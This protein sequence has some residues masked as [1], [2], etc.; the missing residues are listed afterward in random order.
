ME[1]KFS[2]QVKGVIQYSRE[3]A[4]RLGHNYV[5]VEHLLLGLIREGESLA[6]RIL[7]SL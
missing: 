2:P 6:M 4:L 3:E 7:M 1:A 5:G